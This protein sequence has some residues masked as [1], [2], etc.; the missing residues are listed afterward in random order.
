MRK[1]DAHHRNQRCVGRLE[2]IFVVPCM[3]EEKLAE[4]RLHLLRGTEPSIN[5]TYHLSWNFLMYLA[6]NSLSG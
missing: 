2:N 6:H 5:D 4:T 3:W 1:K